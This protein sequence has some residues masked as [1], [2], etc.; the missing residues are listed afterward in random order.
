MVSL[1]VDTGGEGAAE[2]KGPERRNEGWNRRSLT[3]IIRRGEK[4]TKRRAEG[5]RERDFWVKRR[6]IRLNI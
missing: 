5:E 2:R 3:G 1:I 4:E 6:Q